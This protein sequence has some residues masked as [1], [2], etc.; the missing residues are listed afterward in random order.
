MQ[1]RRN[2]EGDL[3]DSK[4][5]EEIITH[6][7]RKISQ[8]TRRNFIYGDLDGNESIAIW[9]HIWWD[10]NLQLYDVTSDDTVILILPIDHAENVRIATQ[11]SHLTSESWENLD[12]RER[13]RKE[14]IT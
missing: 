5:R 2:G 12:T 10:S 3:N 9:R 6:D 1:E 7:D 8:R 13:K 14:K 4:E 11:R